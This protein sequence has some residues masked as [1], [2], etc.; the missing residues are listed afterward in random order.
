MFVR[1]EVVGPPLVEEHLS[2]A[3][4]LL[5]SHLPS[6]KGLRK[7][8]VVLRNKQVDVVVYVHVPPHS[9]RCGLHSRLV[10]HSLEKIPIRLLHTV[11]LQLQSFEFYLVPLL[12]WL[13]LP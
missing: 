6:N 11:S 3:S 1:H 13:R 10:A 8:F 2:A 7:G 9:R 5:L 12:L 4:P